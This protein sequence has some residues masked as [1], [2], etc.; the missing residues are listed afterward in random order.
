M[1]D[2]DSQSLLRF[3]LGFFSRRNPES[4]VHPASLSSRKRE[5]WLRVDSFIQRDEI[6]KADRDSVA[7]TLRAFETMVEDIAGLELDS[8]YPKLQATRRMIEEH[9]NHDRD[10]NLG[11]AISGS[12]RK[13]EIDD[14]IQQLSHLNKEPKKLITDS[15]AN[16]KSKSE[17]YRNAL[18]SALYE[19]Y[20]EDVE[21]PVDK[22]VDVNAQH[23]KYS[24]ALQIA[25]YKGHQEDVQS[26]I[27]S[28]ADVN[29]QDEE[30]GNALYAA[31]YQGH[32]E[33]VQILIDS[34]ANVNAQHERYGS[35]LQAASYK[36]HQEIV[37]ILIDNGAEVNADHP[38]IPF[39]I[40]NLTG[41]PSQATFRDSALGTSIAH[42]S[43]KHSID[44]KIDTS[45]HDMATVE[46]VD[47]RLE[48]DTI[49]TQRSND[50]IGQKVY[51]Y[52]TDL[53]ARLHHELL[54]CAADQE[55][56][57]RISGSL[58]QLLQF[59]AFKIAKEGEGREYQDTKRFMLKHR[60]SI[61]E[62]L[63]AKAKESHTVS[64]STRALLPLDA[65]SKDFSQKSDS[66]IEVAEEVGPEFRKLPSMSYTDEVK[67]WISQVRH[68]ANP[69]IPLESDHE[70]VDSELAF[71]DGIE[72][73]EDQFWETKGDEFSKLVTESRAYQWLLEK[74]RNELELGIPTE[75]STPRLSELVFRALN[76]GQKSS[77]ESTPRRIDAVF[78]AEWSPH[79]F[80]KEQ[81]YG[82]PPDEAVVKAL[83][84][85]GTITQAEGMACG[86]YLLRQW[87]ESAPS[88]IRLVKS[89]VRSAEGTS[90]NETLSDNTKLSALVKDGRL[91]LKAYGHPDS[92]VEIGEQLMWISCA[93]RSS[94]FSEVG[95]CQP[96]VGTIS[97]TNRS[98][99]CVTMHIELTAT[100]KL[101]RLRGSE[102]GA[103][104]QGL[105]QNPLVVECYPIAL[106]CSGLAMGLQLSLNTLM[107]LV[108]D[109]R[110]VSYMGKLFIK[111]FSTL[112]VAV[113]IVDNV[114]LWHVISNKDNSYIY[115][116]DQRVDMLGIEVASSILQQVD[117]A[118]MKHVVGWTPNA[119]NLA[120]TQ[121]GQYQIR[122]SGL[123][124]SRP[125]E[126]ELEKL[127]IGFSKV[128]AG[129]VSVKFGWRDRPVHARDE[130][131]GKLNIKHISKHFVVLYDVEDHRGFL[132][133]GA[134]AL[135]HLVRASI[136]EDQEIGLID[137]LHDGQTINDSI[138]LDNDP[139][140][141]RR[142]MKTLWKDDNA[143]LKLYKRLITGDTKT[144]T[145][146]VFQ[147]PSNPQNTTQEIYSQEERWVF[148]KDRVYDIWWMLDQAINIQTDD[149]ALKASMKSFMGNTK[150][151]GYEFQDLASSKKADLQ[152]ATPESHSQGWLDLVRRLRAVTLF[153]RGFG[154]IIQHND[155]DAQTHPMCPGWRSVPTDRGYLVVTSATLKSVLERDGSD[156]WLLQNPFEPCKPKVQMCDRK[157]F[158]I[159]NQNQKAQT[160][161]LE[162]PERGAVVIG[163]EASPVSRFI[164]SMSTRQ[165]HD[166]D[167][168]SFTTGASTDSQRLQDSRSEDTSREAASSAAAR[169][170][171]IVTSATSY[172]T[173]DTPQDGPERLLVGKLQ[174]PNEHLAISNIAN[175]KL[176]TPLE[177]DVEAEQA[178]KSQSTHFT[179]SN[180][181]IIIPDFNQEGA[182]IPDLPVPEN[183]ESGT[184]RSGTVVVAGVPSGT[185]QPLPNPKS[186]E[187]ASHGR[188]QSV[189][190]RFRQMVKFLP[191]RSS[192]RKDK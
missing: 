83:I 120:G 165:V 21:H 114:I 22:G 116:H 11:T 166:N 151:E 133:D 19:R 159:A 167:K 106:R 81:E 64:E 98:D 124:H 183:T 108:Q 119:D 67:A 69:E 52:K 154:E 161:R 30:H 27:D 132:L 37:Q 63:S 8:P 171:D 147:V 65:N 158:M 84:L 57:A 59:F 135:L 92:V 42:E 160:R 136:I 90:H 68:G 121:G 142:A 113:K 111:T 169:N 94:N 155:C 70:D 148:F 76:E 87:P 49:Y 115:Y 170:S 96:S 112:L 10:A 24:I 55:D 180:A 50:S 86:D 157:H 156:L 9:S 36:G 146:T 18:H 89:V 130:G 128:F 164:K 60:R 33:I 15:G 28:G 93:L 44:H 32:Q 38:N 100:P 25:S 105:F 40:P 12:K 62:Q 95:T 127:T 17:G 173:V 79:S 186:S 77:R 189:H 97:T 149:T 174:H 177:P 192:K 129:N 3:V 107:A 58:P 101:A 48:L 172:T 118:E 191:F 144:E 16:I 168:A 176:V 6:Y 185:L 140:P 78:D 117:I 74:L 99:S 51:E 91:L 20:Q 175:A 150:L 54:L 72:D 61:A 29:A 45:T 41:A 4:P 14:V 35:A 103:C 102:S 110:L 153:G 131:D 2:A 152:F 141:K 23:E 125:L 181:G 56:I 126:I 162:F 75:S 39:S 163:H 46:E 1:D 145:K 80:F 123:A 7:R 5:A 31:S 137:S 26:F 109:S 85:V 34:G 47:D 53:T 179:N 139:D 184:R 43:S 178:K 122:L 104:W 182:Q 134:T 13:R 138:Q 73:L 187:M 88:F 66:V 71:L 82:V 190:G 188:K 143:C